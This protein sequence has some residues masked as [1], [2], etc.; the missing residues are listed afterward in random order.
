MSRLA[1]PSLYSLPHQSTNTFLLHLSD[2]YF[3]LKPCRYVLTLSGGVGGTMKE[4]GV[5]SS[6]F[7]YFF[8]CKLADRCGVI[9]GVRSCI[10]EVA[11]LQYCI[12]VNSALQCTWVWMYRIPLLPQ[13]TNQSVM[14]HA[15]LDHSALAKMT[16]RLHHAREALNVA[17]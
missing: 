5:A 15:S 2:S 8:R 9:G 16:R 12:I 6:A 10:F 13:G 4:R 7:N 1:L 17:C 3:A 11:L 14:E